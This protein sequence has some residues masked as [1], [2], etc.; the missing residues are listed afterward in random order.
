MTLLQRL[1]LAFIPAARRAGAE[2]ETRAWH[3]TC[4]A[5]GHARS[6]WGLGG[7][8]WKASSISVTRTRCPACG[9]TGFH[10]LKKHPAPLS[11]KNL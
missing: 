10:T 4:E 9:T 8:R 6:V 7:V 1:I 3:Y 2:A 5:C 11:G